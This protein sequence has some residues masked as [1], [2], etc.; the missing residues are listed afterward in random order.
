MSGADNWRDQAACKD[1]PTALF[2]ARPGDTDTVNA[3]K[4]ICAT[5]A[6]KDQCLI[7]ALGNEE[8]GG[9]WGGTSPMERRELRRR[10]SAGATIEGVIVNVVRTHRT[11]AKCGTPG[12]AKRHWRQHEP[13]CDPCRVAYNQAAAERMATMRAAERAA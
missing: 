4:A 1:H 7:E 6:V 11:A 10:I 3:A 5:C 12:G 9:T 8:G 13:L 2:F